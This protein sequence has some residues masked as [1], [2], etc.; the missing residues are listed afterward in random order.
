[1][2][3]HGATPVSAEGDSIFSTRSATDGNSTL[4]W[5]RWASLSRFRSKDSGL[6]ISIRD[7]EWSAGRRRI[8][9]KFLYRV[10]EFSVRLFKAIQL[11]P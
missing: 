2:S 4:A 3:G 6:L 7:V 5:A 1:M 11:G 10:T 8:S 9:E